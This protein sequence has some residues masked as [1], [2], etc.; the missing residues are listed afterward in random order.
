MRRTVGTLFAATVLLLTACDDGG[1]TGGDTDGSNTEDT[2]IITSVVL[3]FTAQGA[4]PIVAAFRDLDGEGGESG[5]A[6][7]I[8]LA[9]ST[10]YALSVEF[11]NELETPAEDI[12]LEVA[13]EAEEHQVFFYGASVTGPGATGGTLLTHAYADAESTYGQ[14]GVGED[15]PVGLQN[16]ITTAAAGEGE[17]EGELQVMLRHL[18]ELNG[19]PQKSSDLAA[20]LAS[21]GALPGDADAN[22]RFELSVR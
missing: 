15:L 1:A 14:N 2:E 19:A 6:D 16:T 21:G 3:T 5:M 17:L 12:G 10:E 11:L 13:E 4:E 20:L 8:T 22:V 18:P 7:T 9:A